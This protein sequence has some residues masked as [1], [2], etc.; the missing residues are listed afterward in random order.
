VIGA[1][2][3]LRGGS[4]ATFFRGYF[5]DGF[6][7]HGPVCSISVATRLPRLATSFELD[8]LSVRPLSRDAPEGRQ[9]PSVQR[10]PPKPLSKSA[11]RALVARVW[12]R[13]L[14]RPLR[15]TRRFTPA[16]PALAGPLD[17]ARAVHS[18]VSWRSSP[19]T[20][21]S[22]SPLVTPASQP[23]VHLLDPPKMTSSRAAVKA[24]AWLLSPETPSTGADS[25]AYPLAEV[26]PLRGRLESL[27]PRRYAPSIEDDFFRQRRLVLTLLAKRAREVFPRR[28]APAREPL[29]SAYATS[30]THIVGAEARTTDFCRYERTHGQHPYELSILLRARFATSV[31]VR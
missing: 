21:L 30:A 4:R 3:H 25:S 14:T 19:L 13:A 17:C 5:L 28:L 20:P 7:A 9:G 11:T 8:T 18:R 12:K 31:R 2:H 22:R 27:R 15:G 24:D 1:R 16:E 29:S 10:L 6:V 23:S 26:A